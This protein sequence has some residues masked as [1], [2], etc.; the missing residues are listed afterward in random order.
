M[1]GALSGAAFWIGNSAVL[2]GRD[3]GFACWI[4]QLLSHVS[5]S[6]L[7][8]EA[9]DEMATFHLGGFMGNEMLF[10]C[11]EWIAAA[12]L[13]RNVDAPRA[14]TKVLP[15]RSPKAEAYP[16]AERCPPSAWLAMQLARE[17]DVFTKYA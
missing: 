13:A 7:P 11:Y 8:G 9:W 2:L 16:E 10:R 12:Q 3:V 4:R 6:E 14:Q 15:K 17:S 5:G 1:L